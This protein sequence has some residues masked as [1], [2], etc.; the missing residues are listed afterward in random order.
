[1]AFKPALVIVDVQE[2]FC[3]PNGALAVAG[4]REIVPTIN[5]LLALPFALK[6][7]TKDFHPRDHISFASNHPAPNNKPFKSTIII[8]NPHNPNE[9]QETQL[10]PD[11]CVQGTKGSELVPEL[12]VSKVDK[13]VN[14]GLDKRV[15][16]YSAFADPFK[17]PC[18]ARSDLSQSLREVGVT[19]VYVVGLAADYCVKATAIDSQKEGFKTW[20]VGDATKA[21]DP[22]SLGKVHEEYARLGVAVVAKDSPEVRK[23]KNLL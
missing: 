4:G 23:V 20:V 14:K 12:D 17:N 7:A 19:D 18:V 2:D 1:M 10:W 21:V 11:H 6:V 9:S 22:S 8:K 15:E 5:E 16:M 3:P 13:I